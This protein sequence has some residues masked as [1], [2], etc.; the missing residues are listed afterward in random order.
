MRPVIIG[1]SALLIFKRAVSFAVFPK[2][3]VSKEPCFDM[4]SGET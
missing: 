4:V 1:G 2:F 3:S